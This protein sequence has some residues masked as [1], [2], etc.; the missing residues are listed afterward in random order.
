MLDEKHS[1]ASSKYRS[2]QNLNC[3]RGL[4]QLKHSSDPTITHKSQLTTTFQKL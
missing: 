3:L 2:I 1:S 4:D